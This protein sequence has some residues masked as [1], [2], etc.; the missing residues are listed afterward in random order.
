M[1]KKSIQAITLWI[2]ISSIMNVCMATSMPVI[3]ERITFTSFNAA[4]AAPPMLMVDMTHQTGTTTRDFSL[5]EDSAYLQLTNLSRWPSSKSNE[6]GYFTDQ[7]VNKAKDYIV[8]LSGRVS[9]Y[10]KDNKIFYKKFGTWMDSRGCFGTWED[11]EQA[12]NNTSPLA[13]CHVSS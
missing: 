12:D 11:K 6:M 3:Q 13:A 7:A 1:I 4:C 10:N 9:S 2:G 5:P 8:T